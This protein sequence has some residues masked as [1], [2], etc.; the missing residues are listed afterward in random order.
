MQ[1]D[2]IGVKLIKGSTSTTG[3]LSVHLSLYLEISNNKE[4]SIS[5]YKNSILEL[6]IDSAVLKYEIS[7]DSL[8]YQ[9]G[10]NDKK[11][12]HLV[13]QATDLHYV[14]YKTVE[15]PSIWSFRTHKIEIPH[16]KL[17][18]HLDLHGD[19][20][21]KIEKIIILKPIGTSRQ[22]YEKPPF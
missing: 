17:F 8:I 13:F 14:T 11:L 3:C 12:L 6:R 10:K 4:S 21:E 15:W 22:K 19:K 20:G 1:E 18:L 16:H 5:I 9:L 2:S 7:P